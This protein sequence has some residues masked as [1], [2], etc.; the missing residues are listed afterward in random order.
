MNARRSPPV[1]ADDPSLAAPTPSQPGTGD[2]TKTDNNARWDDEEG[3]WRHPP[4][5]PSDES[6]VDSLGRAVSDVIIGSADET[7]G[8]AK[9]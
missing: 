8:K 3:P 7:R 6:P 1:P 9:P 5:A 2:K 4:V